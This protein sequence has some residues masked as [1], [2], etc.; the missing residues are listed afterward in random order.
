MVLSQKQSP[1][2]ICRV[3]KAPYLKPAGTVPP[4]D[5]KFPTRGRACFSTNVMDALIGPSFQILAGQI[6]VGKYSKSTLVCRLCRPRSE[7]H[8]APVSRLQNRSSVVQASVATSP[9]MA[10]RNL[11]SPPGGRGHLKCPTHKHTPPRQAYVKDR[12][13]NINRRRKKDSPGKSRPVKSCLENDQVQHKKR[14]LTGRPS[15]CPADNLLD[16]H[17]PK[18]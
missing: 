13:H 14:V 17:N 5:P 4:C 7:S 10:G 18:S 6:Q 9:R 16:T 15:L 3:S 12:T 11:I 2:L 8:E 1:C